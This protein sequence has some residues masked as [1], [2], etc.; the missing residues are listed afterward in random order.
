MLFKRKKQKRILRVVQIAK[1]E[2]TKDD[3]I[4]IKT[5]VLSQSFVKLKAIL[6]GYLVSN[7]L[8]GAP[9]DYRRGYL[10][11]I[12]DIENIGNAEESIED[13]DKMVSMQSF[14]D[15]EF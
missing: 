9:D 10:A 1:L 2:W 14:E 13:S 11:A 3:A 5:L 15:D 4:F 7:I 8:A 6:H 12:T